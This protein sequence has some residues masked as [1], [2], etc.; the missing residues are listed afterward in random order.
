LREWKL[1]RGHLLSLNSCE[2]E[3]VLEESVHALSAVA[4]LSKSNSSERFTSPASV[5]SCSRPCPITRPHVDKHVWMRTYP[6]QTA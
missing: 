5:M 6:G 3:H 2:V 4:T 1:K